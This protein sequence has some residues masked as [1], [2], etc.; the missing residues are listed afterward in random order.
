MHQKLRYTL[1]KANI[2]KYWNLSAKYICVHYTILSLFLMLETYHNQISG[3]GEE[4][5][6]DAFDYFSRE[7]SPDLQSSVLFSSL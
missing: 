7:V 5:N 2:T 1:D 4:A 6:E 3:R